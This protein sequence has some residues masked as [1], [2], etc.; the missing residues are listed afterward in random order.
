MFSRRGWDESRDKAVAVDLG[1]TWTRVAVVRNDG[2]I[3]SINKWVTPRTASAITGR[4]VEQFR[5][6]HERG[7]DRMAK[8]GI[9]AVGLLSVKRGIILKAPNLGGM[10]IPIVDAVRSV[11]AGEVKLINDCNAAVLGEKML[12]LG[13]NVAN[14]VYLTI[15]TGIGGGAIVDD[16]LLWGKDGNAA[17]VG[18]IVLDYGSSI[19]CG[20]GGYGHW[21]SMC[22]GV[23]MMKLARHIHGRTLWDS[24]SNILEDFLRGDRKAR[25]VVDVA[26]KLNAAGLASVINSYDPD[27]VTVGG[28]L[29]L[30]Q[31]HLLVRMASRHIRRYQTVRAKIAPTP[32]GEM[33]PLLGAAMAVIH[34]DLA[35]V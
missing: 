4:I 5:M 30:S 14:L 35:G 29:G 32:L 26:S 3:L 34:P 23:G 1:A 12:G 17:E 16:R 6:L 8:V 9:A 10:R 24:S 13:R 7:L 20:C 33:A 25:L 2:T 15:S 27:I 22:S 28:S 18:H 21:E 19:R 11:H 31:K